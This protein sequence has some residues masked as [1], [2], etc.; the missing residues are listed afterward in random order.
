MRILHTSDWHIGVSA[1]QAPREQEHVLFLEWLYNE[2]AER[3]IDV[4][5]HGGDV[6]H[7]VQP[8]ARSQKL[9]Y[10]FLAKCI[11]LPH[12]RHIVIT[13]GNHDS[14]SRLDAPREL[15]DALN[16]T[17]VGGLFGAGSDW[18]Q[19]LCP[20]RND[21]GDVECVIVA[22]PYIHESRLGIRTT[23][24]NAFEIRE[25][26]VAQFRLIYTYLADLA[27]QRYGSVP[28][29]TTGHL[30]CYPERVKEV[31]G[32]FHT[33]LHQIESLG[34]LPPEIFDDR[35]CY[36][37][38]GHIHK[39]MQ[40]GDSNAY[41]SGSPI[42]TD[43]IEAKTP[44]YVM[45][46]KI[47]PSHIADVTKVVVPNWRP[48]YDLQG[49]CEEVFEQIKK[50]QWDEPLAPYLYIDLHVDAPVYDGLTRVSELLNVFEKERR[51]RVVRLKETLIASER[52]IQSMDSFEQAAL[53]E[54]SPAE[55]FEQ[56][57]VLKHEQAPTQQ[58]MSAFSSLLIDHEDSVS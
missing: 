3:K 13:G 32:G 58:I 46:V 6:F 20:V 35:F 48:I 27:E 50:L 7:H 55:V 47:H 16:I 39:M 37:A 23:G 14:A 10:A 57:Y 49:P 41:Y 11:S 9:Y 28:L 53:L 1:E 19:C 29:I 24:R 51:P 45:D 25:E 18:D 30:T 56:M 38:L 44:C 36:I 8:S 26:M 5:V 31:E 4:L 43:I 2:L 21:A 52:E 54:L 40:I 22:V 42:P 12:L 17:V 34:S 15:L 33:P